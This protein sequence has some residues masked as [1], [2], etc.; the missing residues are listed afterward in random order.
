MELKKRL[1]ES[2]DA[3][4]LLKR[5]ME[6]GAYQHA[7][8]QIASVNAEL[9]KLKAQASKFDLIAKFGQLGG[10]V[11]NA[12]D[13]F[14]KFS[15]ILKEAVALV[16]GPAAIGFAILTGSIMGFVNAGLAGTVEGNRLQTSLS[17]LYREIAGVFLPVIQKVT[18]WIQQLTGW[19]R[20]LSGEQQNMI[21]KMSLLASGV[22]LIVSAGGAFIA[23]SVGIVAAI[24][25]IAASMA[26]LDI[27]LGG[28]PLLV[29]AL[30][31]LGIVGAGAGTAL[32]VGMAP[33][34]KRIERIYNLLK[35]IAAV[36]TGGLSNIVLKDLDIGGD[37]HR[38]P[39]LADSGFE[40]AIDTYKR[41]Q[42]S[43]LQASSATAQEKQPPTK[44]QAEKTN[45]YLLFIMQW[46]ADIAKYGSLGAVFNRVGGEIGKQI[47]GPPELQNNGA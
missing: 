20:S 40:S 36:A 9:D 37:T 42:I 35:G 1:S 7:A 12:R 39:T 47:T 26:A 3:A 10:S 25:N 5:S 30:V 13:Q 18:G 43:G 4:D 24:L 27:T 15:G 22:L 45:E 21:M 23:I 16:A 34:E 8:S 31:T 2:N 32:Y 11:I 6:S 19:F 17:Y 41:L 33:A 29:G 38:S 44:E 14:A 46:L 28:I